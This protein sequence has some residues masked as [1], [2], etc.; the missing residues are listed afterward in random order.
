MTQDEI[1]H[2]LARLETGF[3]T[4][5]AH[6]QATEKELA[7]ALQHGRSLGRPQ[8]APD[9]W[10]SRWHRQWDELENILR[11]LRERVDQ[12]DD[13]IASNDPDRLQK[14]LAAWETIEAEDAKLAAALRALYGQA[15][16]LEAAARQEWEALA[17]S[18][19]AHLVTI[20]ACAQAL[21]IK[22][23]LLK[24]HSREETDRL[25]EELLAKLPARDR[26]ATTD[27][28]SA[29]QAYQRAAVE[30]EK[31]RHIF[32]GL[33][34]IVKGLWMWVETPR[35]RTDKNLSSQNDLA[36]KTGL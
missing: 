3:R 16:G 25:I 5:A 12:M 17:Q 9:D 26:A 11:G 33:M 29:R 15:S 35:E 10:G 7:A 13:S 21:R 27:T 18:L 19:A 24:R 14:A 36:G 34:D 31:E 22:L 1:A 23:E 20:H 4:D 8:D 32:M 6:L 2:V 30:L 28:E